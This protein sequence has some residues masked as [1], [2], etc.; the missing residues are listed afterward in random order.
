MV[1]DGPFLRAARPLQP[2]SQ[3]TLVVG[4]EPWLQVLTTDDGIPRPVSPLWAG[5][6][7][8]TATVESV[9]TIERDP[10]HPGRRA[11]GTP[12]KMVQIKANIRGWLANGPKLQ[13]G[14]AYLY[15]RRPDLKRPEQGLLDI[16]PTTQQ[17]IE[18]FMGGA[19]A[20]MQPRAIDGKPLKA[21]WIAY[22]NASGDFGGEPQMVPVP[23]AK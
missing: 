11:D 15:D 3:Y 21:W 14:Y 17:S 20:P 9:G 13:S 22:G 6:E 1:G 19:G 18:L 4:T 10:K 7:A 8:A 16:I 5:L 2:N 23:A 12:S